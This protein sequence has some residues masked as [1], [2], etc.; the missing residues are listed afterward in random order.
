MKFFVNVFGALVGYAAL[1]YLFEGTLLGNPIDVVSEVGFALAF[2]FGVPIWLALA[3]SI[4]IVS[5]LMSLGSY[6]ARRLL[7]KSDAK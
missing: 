4:G 3:L 6:L 5:G 1:S 7:I 2:A